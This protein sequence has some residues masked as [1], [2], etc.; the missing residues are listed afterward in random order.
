MILIRFTKMKIIIYT[1]IVLLS[2]IILKCNPMHEKITS[3]ICDSLHSSVPL[4][5]TYCHGASYRFPL[6]SCSEAQ[7]HGNTLNGGNSDPPSSVSS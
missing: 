4:F 3:P 5:S 6:G 7:C 1:L 2:V